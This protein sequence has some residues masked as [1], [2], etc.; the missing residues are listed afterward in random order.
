MIY[1]YNRLS[2]SIGGPDGPLQFVST[3]ELQRKVVGIDFVLETWLSVD[4]SAK[5]L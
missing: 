1:D 2:S 5:P 4:K 3:T